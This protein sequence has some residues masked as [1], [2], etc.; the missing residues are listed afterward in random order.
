MII[1]F[2]ILS[3]L[4]CGTVSAQTQKEKDYK[5][6]DSLVTKGFV[7]K[8][9]EKGLQDLALRNQVTRRIRE[10]REA[11]KKL[12]GWILKYYPNKS[13]DISTGYVKAEFMVGLYREYACAYPS[14]L[15]KYREVE[16][17]LSALQA[18]NMQEPTYNGS[19]IYSWV[20]E[21]ITAMS[22]AVNAIGNHD[23]GFDIL[24][25]DKSEADL[26]LAL[27]TAEPDFQKTVSGNRD[28]IFAVRLAAATL[29]DSAGMEDLPVWSTVYFNHIYRG[30]NLPHTRDSTAT[31]QCW[32]TGTSPTIR[33]HIH[34]RLERITTGL[35][36]LLPADGKLK[37][38]ALNFN[39]DSTK[40]FHYIFVGK[41]NGEHALDILDRNRWND[42]CIL[43]CGGN[44]AELDEVIAY[45]AMIWLLNDFDTQPQS[46]M[47]GIPSLYVYSKA[48]GP[49]ETYQL[50]ALQAAAEMG[51]LPPIETFIGDSDPYFEYG[52]YS[53]G[54]AYS[55]YFCYFLCQKGILAA[56]YQT[57]H[58]D[59]RT[60]ELKY[61]LE[62]HLKMPMKDIERAFL[63]FI[64]QRSVDESLIAGKEKKEEMRAYTRK[65]LGGM[66]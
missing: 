20:N 28:E 35:Q 31:Y 61:Q 66:K 13:D 24:Q 3:L 29:A 57:M 22:T 59:N 38:L 9:A 48:D 47:I 7:L 37:P 65:F 12:N 18:K 46:W 49:L 64:T 5:V 50:Y 51:K 60:E 23:F 15:G 53:F 16:Y 39:M 4:L 10:F 8:A 6:I 2:L 44:D 11:A 17:L 19:S 63:S 30:L 55:R 40:D 56:L 58:D 52:P 25:S 34:E 36:T 43:N 33:K 54:N 26:A 41:N 14:A 32:L 27:M 1:R 62:T 42:R 21:K 45:T